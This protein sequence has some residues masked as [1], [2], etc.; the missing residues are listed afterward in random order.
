MIFVNLT[1]RDDDMP[2]PQYYFVHVAS[3]VHWQ[4]HKSNQD[5]ASI[6]VDFV[7]RFVEMDLNPIL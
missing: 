5:I 7:E 4:K 2:A 1:L 6:V 3:N